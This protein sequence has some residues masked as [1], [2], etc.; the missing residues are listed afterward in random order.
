MDQVTAFCEHWQNR[1]NEKQ[2]TQS[3][4]IALLGQVMGVED[5]TEAIDFEKTVQLKNKSFIDGYIKKTRVLIEQK[6][7]H[8]DL[9]KGE[10]QSDGTLLTPYQQ[11][12]RYSDNLPY[13]E[14][15]RWIVV[16]NFKTFEIHDMQ[17]PF[18]PPEMLAL[19]DLPREVYRLQF[20]VD[21]GSE[22][23]H[24]EEE[25]SV[26][27]WRIVGEIYDALQSEYLHP[28][29][30]ASMKSL[31]VLCVRLV[32]CLYAEDSGL[33]GAHGLFHDYL[34]Q[35][36]AGQMRDA[37]IA[38]FK[39]LD[40]PEV[41]RDPYLDETLSHFPYVNGGLF[42][43]SAIEI[44]RFN[45]NIADTLLVQASSDFDWSEIS[46][47]IFGAV[48]ESTLNPETRR[49]GGMHYTSVE[50]IHK[51]IDPLFL[52]D[53]AAE[54]DTILAINN[55]NSRGKS[56]GD[57]QDKLAGLS[58]L[59]ASAGSGN[60]LTETY[61]C[62]RK[63]ENTVI[64]ERID[65]QKGQEK[66]QVAMGTA[67]NPIAV[68]IRQ[69]YGIEIN[70]FA[71]TVARTALW[72]AESQ[73]FD[74][75]MKILYSDFDF[76]PL[77]TAAKIVEG[78]ALTLDWET[79]VPKGELDYIMGN[80]PFL[81]Y[82]MQ[83]KE[84]KADL[85]AVYSN[86]KG[87]P[88]PHS[89][90][91]DF[92]S[93][94]YLKAARYMQDTNISAAFVFTNSI[95]QGDQ[96]A[97]IWKPVLEEYHMHLHFGY[98]TFKWQ[99]EAADKAAVHCV[100]I[101]FGPTDVQPKLIFQEAN[102][103][104]KAQQLNAYLLDAPNVL[105]ETRKKPL[106]DVP[107]MITGNRPADGGNLIIEQEDYNDFVKKDPLSKKYIRP[108]MGSR[109]FINRKPRHCLWLVHCPPGEL[110]KMPEVL[111]RVRAC[112]ED[113]LRAK[114]AGRRKLADTPALMR[115]Q[116]E[117]GT[118]Y[119][120]IPRVSSERR[121]Y[122]PIGY[123]KAEVIV[124]DAV[125]IIPG[126]T[127]YHF[128]ILTS[129]V[130]NAWMRAVAGRLKSDYRYSKDI[131][132]NNFPWP[133]PTPEQKALIEK[134]AAA[135]LHARERYPQSSLADLYDEAVMP[136]EL[137]NAHQNNDLAVMRAYGFSV[138]KMDEAACVAELM[139]RYQALTEKSGD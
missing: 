12:K 101:G 39:V 14:R 115:E 112:R 63:L 35:Y 24:R 133:D 119:I 116:I 46:P 118:E 98:Q 96:V 107:E 9:R 18:A 139:K 111:K 109:E 120:V 45:Q 135:I 32:F 10:K 138:K 19:S 92:V 60:F 59:D 122:V 3:F 102:Q 28:E 78:N 94:W 16:C 137:R 62:L 51:V 71:V 55:L 86:A 54:L 47:T 90:K 100:I 15:A 48:F 75:T 11:A 130:H 52:N 108:F 26:Q 4:W 34:R 128:G 22:D 136:P 5:P 88:Y 117:M 31:N 126:S 80:P 33:F 29:D 27:A 50:N 89:G 40:T 125:L 38:L 2:D 49:S 84:Q 82:S 68:S 73:M 61:L 43:D 42:A 123:V 103:P 74:E 129:N 134:T 70:D 64:R 79:V 44:P 127:L 114:D 57:F 25:V 106:C 1:G 66:G 65:I 121:R 30:P 77:T 41:A 67:I 131:V 95:T 83:N 72:I 93:G 17:T 87:K 105:I 13:I 124:S 53:L 99:S 132:Y 36:T 85:K 37:V 56:L 23:I 8:I 21:A 81:G 6:G 110:R 69:F 97:P 7:A 91:I 76:L 58:F 104:V 113:R 20:L